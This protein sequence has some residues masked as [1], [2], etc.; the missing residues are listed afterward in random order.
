MTKVANFMCCDTNEIM[1]TIG[2]QLTRDSQSPTFHKQ[3]TP[4]R[5]SR[6]D[7]EPIDIDNDGTRKSSTGIC[8]A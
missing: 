7:Q 3:A 5:Q 6:S 1:T 4:D 2:V 8:Y